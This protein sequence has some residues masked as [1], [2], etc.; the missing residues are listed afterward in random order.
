M[1]CCQVMQIS[2]TASCNPLSGTD[3]DISALHIGEVNLVGPVLGVAEQKLGYGNLFI[4]SK[5]HWLLTYIRYA[6]VGNGK[7][8]RS[9]N[10]IDNFDK[11]GRSTKSGFW[12]VATRN[13][14]IK[15]L[16]FC[17]FW[18]IPVSV[19]PKTTTQL[20]SPWIITTPEGPGLNL[21]IFLCPSTN[22]RCE[23]VTLGKCWKTYMRLFHNIACKSLI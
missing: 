6:C 11:L 5:F 22:R 2:P 20:F 9:T 23:S 7:P 16:W 1:D 21:R 8:V 4:S 13:I 17:A 14:F 10:P 18:T 19:H 15:Y 12:G 3:M